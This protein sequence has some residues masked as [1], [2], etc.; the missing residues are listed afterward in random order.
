ME[1]L[2]TETNLERGN[3][4]PVPKISSITP[5]SAVGAEYLRLRDETERMS[6]KPDDHAGNKIPDHQRLLQPVESIGDYR[7]DNHDNRQVCYY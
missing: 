7:T 6:K 1:T 5:R 3:F 2:P 4:K